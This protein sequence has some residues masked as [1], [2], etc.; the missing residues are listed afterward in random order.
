M[1]DEHYKNYEEQY[2]KTI[3]ALDTYHK[4]HKELDKIIKKLDQEVQ[5]EHRQLLRTARQKAKDQAELQ[6]M[7][8]ENVETSK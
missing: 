2:S 8:L 5:K 1:N 6:T 3:S 7:A 4:E